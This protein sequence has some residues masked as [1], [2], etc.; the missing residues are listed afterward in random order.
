MNLY[1][2]I[3]GLTKTL[4][5]YEGNDSDFFLVEIKVSSLL[6]Y[7]S[8]SEYIHWGGVKMLI[9]TGRIER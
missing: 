3:I 6:I 1:E 5:F 4:K 9:V 2:I 7:M 8:E